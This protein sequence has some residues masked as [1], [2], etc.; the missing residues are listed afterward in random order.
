MSNLGS[1][2]GIAI[3]GT[4]LT[5][6]LSGHAYAAAMI[7]LAALGIAGLIIAAF[8]PAHPGTAHPP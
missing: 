1:S 8:L 7:T 5:A 3:A 6:G 2:L 4:I